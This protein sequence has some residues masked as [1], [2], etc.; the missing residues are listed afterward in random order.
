M[1]D[2][3]WVRGADGVHCAGRV[4]CAGGYGGF[5]KSARASELEL[6]QPFGPTGRAPWAPA[7]SCAGV[8]GAGFYC[9][10]VN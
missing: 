1:G 8:D 6:G 9:T 4:Y 10:G 2:A 5:L 3:E 7:G